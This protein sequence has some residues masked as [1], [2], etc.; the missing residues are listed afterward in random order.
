M[1]P[2]SITGRRPSSFIWM[3]ESYLTGSFLVVARTFFPPIFSVFTDVTSSTHHHIFPGFYICFLMDALTV[4]PKGPMKIQI[5]FDTSYSS[6]LLFRIKFELIVTWKSLKDLFLNSVAT[7]SAILNSTECSFK[8]LNQ[9]LS[10][11]RL[12]TFKVW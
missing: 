11:L 8:N 2:K 6:F 4:Q 9:I 5:R 1:F 12:K 10:F 7:F 3:T